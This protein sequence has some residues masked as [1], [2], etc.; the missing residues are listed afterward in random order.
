MRGR[1]NDAGGKNLKRLA[2]AV[3]AVA[4]FSASAFAAASAQTSATK[5]PD[6][7]IP[8][9]GEVP[10]IFNDQHVYAKPDK[11]TKGRVLAALVRGTTTLVPLR[12][13][14]EQMGAT[15]TYTAATRTVDVSKP[16]VDV[17]VTVGKNEVTLNGETRPLDVPP[18]IYEGAVVVPARV[19]SESLGA[20]VQW[21][22]QKRLVAVRFLSARPAATPPPPPPSTPA[23]AAPPAP[24]P[25]PPTETLTPTPA[26]R[27]AAELFIAGDALL[28]P[29]IYD[30]F[31]PGSKG[32][33]SI[34]ARAG[35][36]I[37]VSN[38]SFLAEAAFAEFSG[39]H[40][41]AAGFDPSLPCGVEG[42]PPAANP[43]CVSVLGP[44]G[45]SAEVAPF[46]LHN[47]DVDGRLGINV[48]NPKLFLVGS[49]ERFSGNYGYPILEGPGAGLEKLPSFQQLLDL[50]GSFL[51]YPQLE[52]KYIDIF[53]NAQ[54][55]QYRFLKYQA[56]L[57]FSPAS[58]PVF[59]DAG[60]LGNRANAKQNAPADTTES[61][62]YAGLGLHF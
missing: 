28:D 24:A 36:T 33:T 20:Y 6:F 51:Y 59:L 12:S 37:P 34:A 62:F 48:A 61:G 56:G 8:P 45:G 58:L 21:V 30:E 40:G 47:E 53:G 52:G 15:V 19:I 31:I 1:H 60:F 49:Y 3:L 39:P 27:P 29:K 2:F 7:G 41:G 14:F 57:V 17:Q 35:A 44:A 43:S 16:G 42:Q 50:Y 9:S 32:N 18:E 25:Q 55:L 46:R 13:M 22:P 23:P 4:T 5:R 54:Q 38:L 26:E 10:L 11:L